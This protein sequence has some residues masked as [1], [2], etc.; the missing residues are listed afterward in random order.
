VRV[1]ESEETTATG[2]AILAAVGA[3]VHSGVTDAVKAFV[4]FRP[5][6]HEPDPSAGEAYDEAYRRYRELYFALV[7]IFGSGS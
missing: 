6:E 5:D 7:P 3:G 4:S 2:A 1:P